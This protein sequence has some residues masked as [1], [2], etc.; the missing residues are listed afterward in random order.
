MVW[1]GLVLLLLAG[2][3]RAA[4][5]GWRDEDSLSRALGFRVRLPV[6]HPAPDEPSGEPL[7]LEDLGRYP[8]RNAEELLW[9]LLDTR[10][11]P[12]LDP[13]VS[14]Y[15]AD[16]GERGISVQ[17]WGI[18]G[19]D[20]VSL[21]ELLQEGYDQ[22]MDGAFLV[23]DLPA[24]FYRFS[25]EQNPFPCELFFMDLDG[26]WLD[27]DGDGV[28]DRHSDP[29]GPEI[30]VGRVDASRLSFGPGEEALLANYFAK[31]H[32]YRSGGYDGWRG[33][34]VYVDD[35]FATDTPRFAAD[36]GALA[37]EL[38]VE[39]DAE[40]T[41]GPDYRQ[42]LTAG[43]RWIHV[44]VH[45]SYRVH[46]FAASEGGTENIVSATELWGI[47]PRA[48]FYSLYACGNARFH[49]TDPM[50]IWYVMT[51]TAG[52]AAFG[53][54]RSGAMFF[55]DALLEPLDR[56][57]T[58]GRALLDWASRWIETNP[59]WFYG[60]VLLGDPAL[61]AWDTL[62]VCGIE[63]RDEA[64]GRLS[65]G[66]SAAVRLTLRNDGPAPL[67]GVA[68][69]VT[70][71]D[72]RVTIAGG[73]LYVERC[74]RNEEAAAAGEL[75]ITVAPDAEP[76]RPLELLA[77]IELPEGGVLLEPLR[78]PL[79]EAAP[80][81][82]DYELVAGD[83]W[84]GS[85]AHVRFSISNRGAAPFQ[86]EVVL[87][88]DDEFLPGLSLR[89]PGITVAPGEEL[90]LPAVA[91]APAQ[92]LPLPA[93]PVL[94][95]RFEGP[96]KTF[97]DS[98]VLPLGAGS[99]YRGDFENG[100]EGCRHGAVTPG[101]PDP[102][103]LSRQA[104]WEGEWGWAASGAG[105]GEPY[106]TGSDAAL[107]L[108]PVLLSPGSTLTFMHRM[109]VEPLWDGAVVEIDAGNGWEVAMPEGGYDST[110]E[111]GNMMGYVGPC[112]NGSFDW[113]RETFDLSAW[114]G[115]IRVRFRFTTDL[116]VAR[117]GWFIDGIRI[118]GAA[119]LPQ[120]GIALQLN[121]GHF[122]PRSDFLLQLRTRGAEA[123]RETELYVALD[124]GEGI[125]PRYYFYPDWTVTPQA[126]PLTIAAGE[127]Q[128]SELLRFSFPDQVPT[129]EQ[130]RFLGLLVDPESGEPINSLAAV[131]F[132]IGPT[133]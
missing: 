106:P 22:G 78:L 67:E 49:E 89:W 87:D 108:P 2:T 91:I 37:A 20:A 80:V 103:K 104:A 61:R 102:W 112:W 85:S 40:A 76:D 53:C 68:V 14:Q 97:E 28:Y 6:E 3:V 46:Y 32:S 13:A 9:V 43:E 25:P 64:D 99:G 120:P 11:R 24:A 56:G 128:T 113:R 125:S 51:S 55:H 77:A 75:T 129:L 117:E 96:L 66:E 93:Y 70:S 41:N 58:L 94:R 48:L 118:S 16:L 74:G 1:S 122:G 38:T 59:Y 83:L 126:V 109:E 65:P 27:S 131:A 90:R 84:P 132:T 5:P 100:P 116:G 60:T 50:G 63:V 42:R 33:A 23:G 57:A 130:C 88:G 79:A 35:D 7:R 86:G 107:Y 31:L 19:G 8:A 124:L 30:Y 18:S 72:P 71:D 12:G 10:L 26:E 15:I 114:D 133:P 119:E 62:S 21:R 39:S 73:P 95:F 34:L 98:V 29:S 69:T 111:P 36:F 115:V 127:D 121:A 44:A 101:C 123:T 110:L 17:L 81:V 47:D 4:P 45:S 52:L 54:T 92:P 82:S 105:P